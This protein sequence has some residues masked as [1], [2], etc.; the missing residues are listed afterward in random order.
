VS[1]TLTLPDYGSVARHSPRIVG[2]HSWNYLFSTNKVNS[3]RRGRTVP[4]T[5]SYCNFA[6]ST[7]ACFRMGTSGSESFQSARKSL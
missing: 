5:G 4:A 3:E 1:A 7:F 6:N 2:K